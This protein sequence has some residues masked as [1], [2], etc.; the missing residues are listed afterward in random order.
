MP[1]ALL[2]GLREAEAEWLSP[3]GP[4]EASGDVSLVS[5]GDEIAVDAADGHLK[6]GAHTKTNTSALTRRRGH[7]TLLV[8]GRLVATLVGAVERTN[9]LV[10]VQ[11][12]RSRCVH[13]ES[14]RAFRAHSY[15][16]ILLRRGML[17]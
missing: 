16:D 7:G 12:T 10:V 1:G 14:S 11:P 13:S 2:D 15:A 4:P 3:A 9:K 17:L 6:C 5:P 8:G